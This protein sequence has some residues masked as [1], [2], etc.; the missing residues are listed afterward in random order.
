MKFLLTLIAA[1]AVASGSQARASETLEGT[2]VYVDDGDTVSL[3]VSGHDQVKI[4]LASIDAPES[5]HTNHETGRVGQ[6]YSDVSKRLLSELVK[7]KHVVAEC[8]DIDRYG[9]KVCVLLV[10]GRSA[11]AEMV[12][13]GL[14]WANTAAGGRYLRDRSLL[15]LQGAAQRDRLGLWAGQNPVP[16]WEWRDRCW[17]ANVCPQ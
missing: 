1:L 11:N 2:V 3:L 7:G 16:P 15:A 10:D 5:S 9:R 8:P 17:K 4:R 6:P 14:A 12:R 13:A